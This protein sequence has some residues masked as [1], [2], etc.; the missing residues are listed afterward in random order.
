LSGEGVDVICAVLGA[1]KASCLFIPLDPRTPPSR[2]AAMLRLASPAAYVVG[3]DSVSGPVAAHD[4]GAPILRLVDGMLANPGVAVAPGAVHLEEM[5]PD[6]P[7]YLYFT[8]GSTGQP[9][10]ITGRFK[11]IAHFIRWEIE[12]LGVEVGCRV[13]QLI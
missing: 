11:S 4:P 8:S 12:V 9:K 2:L 3:D 5:G 7:C 6:D 10:A 1:L 13:S